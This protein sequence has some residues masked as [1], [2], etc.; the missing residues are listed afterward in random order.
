MYK[1]LIFLPPPTS[2]KLILC[3][4]QQ[5]WCLL[6]YDV[7]F[8][9]CVHFPEVAKMFASNLYPEI[10]KQKILDLRVFLY[11][12]KMTSKYSTRP[13]FHLFHFLVHLHF[14]S[15][16]Y[17]YRH[18]FGGSNVL[19]TLGSLGSNVLGVIGRKV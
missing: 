7:T 11:S 13:A 6:F 15:G 4:V 12:R 2:F 8:W 19:L 3:P 10:K 18:H 17:I 1:F 14:L 9:I 16:N 5:T